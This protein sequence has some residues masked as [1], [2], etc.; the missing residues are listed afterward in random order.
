M[1]VT[2]E[3][4][5]GATKPRTKYSPEQLELLESAFQESQYPDTETLENL[6][7]KLDVN[8]DKV[9][10]WFQNRRSKFKRQSK[11]SHVA[12]MRKQF[13]NSDMHSPCQ[14]ASGDGKQHVLSPPN[15]TR[16]VA[17]N[18]QTMPNRN[19]HYMP[20]VHSDSNINYDY[21]KSTSQFSSIPRHFPLGPVSYGGT[22]SASSFW[23]Q[24]DAQQRTRILSHLV[25][26][27]AEQTYS[28][29]SCQYTSGQ[30]H[31]TT[32][33]PPPHNVASVTNN[34]LGF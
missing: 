29:P 33:F 1:G 8:T 7:E 25:S 12:W 17:E 30:A 32:Q 5:R 23:D 28:R 21:Q 16:G 20:L 27:Q 10:V 2:T 19:L 31:S 6:A 15:Q 3:S 4:K 34:G 9:S 11:N 24:M 26:E 22:P 13:Y 18:M 14:L